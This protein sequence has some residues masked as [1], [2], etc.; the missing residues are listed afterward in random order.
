MCQFKLEL[1]R[2]CIKD[3]DE[4]LQLD[5]AYAP[6]YLRKGLALEAMGK[7][8]ESQSIYQMGLK[9]AV[10][11]V[12]TMLAILR[13]SKGLELGTTTNF[14]NAAPSPTPAPKTAVQIDEELLRSD[15]LEAN[16]VEAL[17]E[18][19]ARGMV[20]N[21]SGDTAIDQRI[22]YGNLLVNTGKLPQA[23][24]SFTEL[25]DSRPSTLAALLG[26]GTAL[27][28]QGSFVESRADLTAALKIAPANVDALKRRA[29]VNSALGLDED[30]LQ[31]L[32]K[33]VTLDMSADSHHQ[34]GVSYYK[35]R[36][37]RR[38]LAD[39]Q[40]SARLDHGNRLT[41]NYMGQCHICL[42]EGARA[43][44]CY[45]K[46]LAL[47]PT[48]QDAEA[49]MGQAY[50]EMADE[51]KALEHLTVALKENS[52]THGFYL[53]GWTY[54]SMGL[55]KH[56]YNDFTQALKCDRNF[57]EGW[58]MRGVTSSGLGMA[59][60]AV[61]D[62]DSAITLRPEHPAWYQRQLALFYHH[63]LDTPLSSFN[64]D[65]A[66]STEFKEAWCKR[67]PPTSQLPKQPGIQKA[68][69][70]VNLNPSASPWLLTAEMASLI[71]F[72][73]KVGKWVHQD[74][75][76]FLKNRRQ[77]AMAGFAAIELA[78][79]LRQAWGKPT[80]TTTPT[81]SAKNGHT[82]Q[83]KGKNGPSKA[84]TTASQTASHET[85]STTSKVDGKSSS[86]ERGAHAF[87]WRD[88]YDIV[89]KW[90]QYSEPNDPVWWVDLLTK[91]AFS[92][93][94]GSHTPIITGQCKVIRYGRMLE[95]SLPIFKKLV[96]EQCV[97]S[98]EAKNRVDDATSPEDLYGLL[99]RDYF[100]VTP[101]HSTAVPGKVMEGT[102]LTIQRSPPEGFEYSIR[103]PGTPPRWVDYDVELTHLFELLTIDAKKLF[104]E[105]EKSDHTA[106]APEI[107]ALKER[108][109]QHILTIAFYWYNFMPLARGTAACGYISILGMFLA[110]GTHLQA[111]IPSN[112]MLDWDAILLP[113]SSEFTETCKEWMLP[114]REP[115]NEATFDSLPSVTGSI[116]TLRHLFTVLNAVCQQ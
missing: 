83:A 89:V 7:T 69:A 24:K 64:I 36:N 85:S 35:L 84:K 57:F 40:A 6:A 113:T 94:F 106:A 66:L 11:D 88:M 32:E 50:K 112:V 103:T 53:R 65:A 10:G 2:K 114:H 81:T 47:D 100:V 76:G 82:P 78:Q 95:R 93:G 74:S 26:R 49:N 23:I 9:E 5:S 87:G 45:R 72:A 115:L 12:D 98:E 79:A 97:L 4:A 104:A 108:I 20:Q 43:I 52:Y 30:A 110:T 67:N 91:E 102:R 34:R 92:E 116:P 75:P 31:D 99:N 14:S 42:G 71:D 55:H 48:F 59:Q 109:T 63:H 77:I 90:R 111:K 73:S 29:Q 80:K 56:A 107:V 28:L 3:C 86:K 101:C 54:F 68:I 60:S 13:A 41:Y 37:Y 18:V 1:Y 62:F 39:F 8:I 46:A 38:A 61:S 96:K 25:L 105:N 44:E 33:C 15:G 27:A 51:T 17:A 22:A 70:D 58:W 16:Q 21:T 19:A